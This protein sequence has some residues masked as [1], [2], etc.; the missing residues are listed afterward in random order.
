MGRAVY[1]VRWYRAPVHRLL[2]NSGTSTE[3]S[4]VTPC[5]FQTESAIVFH[6]R[7]RLCLLFTKF[8]KISKEKFF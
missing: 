6:V 2:L 5:V 8:K 1:L 3:T 4:V 7:I